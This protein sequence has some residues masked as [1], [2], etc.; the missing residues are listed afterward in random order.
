MRPSGGVI[1]P[2]DFLPPAE[3]DIFERVIIARSTPE[4]EEAEQ[5]RQ[6]LAELDVVLLEQGLAK[7]QEFI[8]NQ[9]AW[10]R[11]AKAQDDIYVYLVSSNDD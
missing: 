11:E 6:Y 5:R 1:R 7:E 9:E 4:A 2:K 3:V 10:R 8:D